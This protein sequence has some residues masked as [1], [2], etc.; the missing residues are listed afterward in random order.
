M[1]DIYFITVGRNCCV[2]NMYKFIKDNNHYILI[3]LIVSKYFEKM[4]YNQKCINTLD[5]VSNQTHII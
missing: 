4:S 5:T 2:N 3:N 1:E